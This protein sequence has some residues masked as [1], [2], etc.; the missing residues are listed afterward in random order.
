V[1]HQGIHEEDLQT[2]SQRKKKMGDLLPQML[3]GG[4]QN[5]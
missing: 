2:S 1:E 5:L 4:I 3:L